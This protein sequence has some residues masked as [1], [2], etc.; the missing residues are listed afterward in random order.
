MSSAVPLTLDVF[1]QS[2]SITDR[3]LVYQT[4]KGAYVIREPLNPPG[5]FVR[6][7]AEYGKL[8]FAQRRLLAYNGSTANLNLKVKPL[9]V[10]EGLRQALTQEMGPQ[11]ESVIRDARKGAKSVRNVVQAVVQGTERK[12]LK[13]LRAHVHEVASYSRGNIDESR[14]GHW[15]KLSRSEGGQWWAKFT[16]PDSPAKQLA[17]AA[18]RVNAER[19]LAENHGVVD[20]MEVA[21][22]TLSFCRKLEQVPAFEHLCQFKSEP[23]KME[24]FEATCATALILLGDKQEKSLENLVEC[25]HSAVDSLNQRARAQTRD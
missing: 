8:E 3:S 16:K 13:E 6:W 15:C 2:A 1:K 12:L 21:E 10:L 20:L 11:A 23:L 25:F 24:M 19:Q 9:S 5:R 18:F 17:V 4:N 7:L 22:D 14:F